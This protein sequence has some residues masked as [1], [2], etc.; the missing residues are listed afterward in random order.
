MSFFNLESFYREF[1]DGMNLS[2]ELVL[3]KADI[4]PSRF[5][6][7]G[8]TVSKEEYM[9]VMQSMDEVVPDEYMLTAGQLDL[10]TR[11]LPPLFAALCSKDGIRCFERLS[12]Y[13]KLIGPFVLNVSTDE[14]YLHLEFVF[15]DYKTEIPRFT[16]MTE[17]VLMTSILRQGT[18]RHIVPCH[19]SSRY[20][21]NKAL[22]DYL[23]VTPTKSD[24]N[25]LSFDLNDMKEP[26]LTKNNVMWEY[27]EPEL[28][29]RLEQIE[30][31]HSFAAQV[32]RTLFE[33][34]PAGHGTIEDVAKELAVSART[35]Q[36]KLA[37]EDTTFIK[38]LNHTRELMARNYLKDNKIT[39][40]EIAF[41][42]GYSDA[43]AFS[44]AFRTWTGITIGEYRKNN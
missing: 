22:V 25:I 18:G 3:K 14:S 20:D 35:L 10:M 2:L 30:Q 33:L 8:L 23:G 39:N 13:K 29:K 4:A 12:K 28:T 6:D 31:D 40:D 17:Q 37:K 27:I 1:L 36:R 32:R 38:Q 7:D 11:F 42:I 5:T 34:I 26:F 15:D 41:L 43:N 44:R 19:V 9:R 16:I 21:Y 24:R